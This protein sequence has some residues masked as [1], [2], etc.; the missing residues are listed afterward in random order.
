MNVVANNNI[1]FVLLR[2]RTLIYLLDDYDNAY[3]VV[4]S[5]HATVTE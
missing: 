5:T 1:R 2:M 3:Y 4:A